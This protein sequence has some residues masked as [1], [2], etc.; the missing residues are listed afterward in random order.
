MNIIK[1]NTYKIQLPKHD[2]KYNKIIDERSLNIIYFESLYFFK[3]VSRKIKAL[4]LSDESIQNLYL[5]ARGHP[6]VRYCPYASAYLKWKVKIEGRQD[7]REI[8]NGKKYSKNIRDYNLQLFNSQ[9]DGVFEKL[10]LDVLKPLY[11]KDIISF[12]QFKTI[13]LRFYAEFIKKDF[14]NILLSEFTMIETKSEVP[15]LI[16]EGNTKNQN[17]FHLHIL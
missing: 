2:S 15:Q 14:E 11:E 7:F 8:D 6:N 1:G 4:Y 10:W 3:T 5:L 13:L 17:E 12:F 16:L 9:F